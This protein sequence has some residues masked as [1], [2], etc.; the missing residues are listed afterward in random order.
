MTTP[1]LNKTLG[2]IKD[3]TGPGTNIPKSNFTTSNNN[4]EI[5]TKGTE[6]SFFQDS[7]KDKFKRDLKNA[8]VNQ[9]NRTIV[10]RA[11]LLNDAIDQIRNQI[12]YAGRMSEPTNVYTGTNAFRNDI[13]NALRNAVGASIT[14][15]FKKPI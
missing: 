2:N 11:K 12:P 4:T 14:G 3:Q 7:V 6:R 8:V 9:I 5:Q 1:V 15:F 10:Q 13:I